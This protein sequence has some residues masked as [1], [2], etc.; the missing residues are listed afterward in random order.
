MGGLRTNLIGLS[1]LCLVCQT[2][3]AAGIRL[4]LV[5]HAVG[6]EREYED[7]LV[8]S[9]YLNDIVTRLNARFLFP[10]EIAVQLGTDDGPL[11]DVASRTIRIPFDLGLLPS[12]RD[13]RLDMVER[14]LLYRGALAFSVGHE[15]GHAFVHLYDWPVHGRAEEEQAADAVAVYL[16]MHVLGDEESVAEALAEIVRL[17]A[18]GDASPA[19][20]AC[21]APARAQ[22]VFCWLRGAASGSL[23]WLGRLGVLPDATSTSCRD[24][25]LALESRVEALLRPAERS[26]R[27]DPP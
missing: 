20:S 25:Y 26:A 6:E 21:I 14:R 5:R 27:S 9:R 23:G 22:R 13:E 8:H 2:G 24:E 15:M 19:V 4:Q 3:V 7:Y 10:Q 18:D 16:V 11:Y 17:E 12:P 1:M